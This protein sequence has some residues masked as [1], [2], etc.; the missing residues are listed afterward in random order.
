MLARGGRPRFRLPR[1]RVP[2]VGDGLAALLEISARLHGMPHVLRYGAAFGVVLATFGLCLAVPALP[3]AS[4]FLP[5]LPGVVFNALVL[6][7]G[8]GAVS[9][10]LAAFLAVAYLVE[11]VGTLS[12]ADPG[13][14][15]ALLFFAATGAAISLVVE[16]LHRAYFGLKA[17]LALAEAARAEAEAERTSAVAAREATAAAER[18]KDLMLRELSHRLRNDLQ[19]LVSLLEMQVAS[20]PRGS[21]ARE[22]LS[23]AAARTGIVARAHARLARRGEADAAV[24]TGEFLG[25]LCD[26]LRD[27]HLGGGV[28]P[29]VRL[30]A[31]VEDH[32]LALARAVPLG[33]V[34]NELATNALKHAFPAGRAG[35]VRVRFGRRGADDYALEV[36]DDGVGLPAP[37]S[38]PPPGNRG[39]GQGA[40]IARALARRVGG[41]LSCG[42]GPGGVGTLCGL[43]FPVG[44]RVAPA[45]AVPSPPGDGAP[46]AGYEGG[47]SEATAAS[48]AS[49]V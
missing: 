34:A 2:R 17:T 42:P 48:S 22:A 11:P 15:L 21:A 10:L 35:T 37:D 25:G 20:Q 43:R 46:T 9:A 32:P 44:G 14:A 27:A 47:G 38:R 6:D 12:V 41:D 31:E 45:A 33:L 19:T 29:G 3:R 36:E 24:R 40:A 16:G 7:R 30:L 39:G 23:A 26:D 28:R 1:P 8:S 5:F 4:P 18:G 49:A 13:A